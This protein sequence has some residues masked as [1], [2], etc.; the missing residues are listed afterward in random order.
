MTCGT[1]KHLAVPPNAKGRR[2]VY[3][4]RVYPCTAT[5][6]QPLLPVCMTMGYGFKWPPARSHMAPDYG[7]G[8]PLHE[9]VNR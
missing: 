1:C 2:V 4:H 9:P 6:E 8:C 7:D 5:V 3:K